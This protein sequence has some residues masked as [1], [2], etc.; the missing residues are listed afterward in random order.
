MDLMD[1]VAEKVKILATGPWTEDMVK[2]SVRP[3]CAPYISP[4]MKESARKKFAVRKM[5]EQQPNLY[6]GDVMH[7][8]AEHSCITNREAYFAMGQIKYSEY[9]IA[10]PEVANAFGCTLWDLPVGMGVNAVIVTADEKIVMMESSQL[11]DFPGMIDVPGGSY[12]SGTPFEMVR[13]EICEEVGIRP[14][15]LIDTQF[16][17]ISIRLDERIGHVLSFCANTALTSVEVAERSKN[18]PDRWEGSV[19]FLKCEP[20]VVRRYV[21]EKAHDSARKISASCFAALVLAGRH[22]WGKEWSKIK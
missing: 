11:V 19:F 22:L 13:K 21:N 8:C 16:L 6:D 7:L 2:I 15:E 20:E 4:E 3:S 17:G 14:E 1:L 18:A 10:T 9:C 5:S 12:S